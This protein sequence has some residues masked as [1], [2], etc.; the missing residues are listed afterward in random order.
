MFSEDKYN[1]NKSLFDNNFKNVVQN[2]LNKNGKDKFDNEDN[3]FY[4]DALC[5]LAHLGAYD[6]IKFLVELGANI[7]IRNEQPIRNAAEYA[8]LNKNC[9]MVYN[10]LLKNGANPD[11][12]GDNKFDFQLSANEWINVNKQFLK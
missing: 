6:Q 12:T 5:H 11:T 1:L 3:D 10:Y 8:Y 7:H 4:D 2:D 9:K